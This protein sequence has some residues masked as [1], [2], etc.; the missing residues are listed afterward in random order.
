MTRPLKTP[1]ANG[2]PADTPPQPD[3]GMTPRQ[4]GKYWRRSADA[5]RAAIA[6]GELGA[7]VSHTRRGTVRYIVLPHHMAAYEQRHAAATPRPAP[8]RRGRRPRPTDFYP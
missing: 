5:I 6:A 1:A 3:R 2:R 8:R 7:I 4:L